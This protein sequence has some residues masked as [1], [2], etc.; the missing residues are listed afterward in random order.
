MDILNK[1][2]H[3]I[4]HFFILFNMKLYFSLSIICIFTL[5]GCKKHDDHSDTFSGNIT[6]VS[7]QEGDTIHGA[8]V[9]F[10]I[11]ATGNQAMHGW[12]YG[13]HD[14]LNSTLVYENDAHAHG[15]SLSINELVTINLTDTTT[16]RID[17]EF[18]IDD[19]GNSI[20][21]SIYCVWIP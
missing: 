12:Y 16:L 15:E 4:F 17:S 14:T 3:L 21:K 6:F 19:D 2:K 7:P 1:N 10:Q 20:K 13:I 18:A 8:N 11:N 5:I 9:Q